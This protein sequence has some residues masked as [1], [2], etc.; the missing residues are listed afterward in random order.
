MEK[1]NIRYVVPEDIAEPPA[2]VSID[3]SLHLFDEGAAPGAEADDGRRG[4]RLP[5]QAA[6]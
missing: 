2:F 3:V 5:D 1:T 4:G 6:V